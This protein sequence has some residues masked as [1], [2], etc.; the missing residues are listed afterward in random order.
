MKSHGIRLLIIFGMLTLVGIITFQVF[1]VKKTYDIRVSHFNQTIS[2]ALFDVAVK[3]ADYNK[4]LLQGKTPVHQVSTNSFIVEVN[5]MIDKDVLELFLRREFDKRN[6][7]LDFEYAIFDCHENEM[8]FGRY[9]SMSDPHDT[10]PSGH[11]FA[12]CEDC[13]YYFNIHFPSMRT[14]VISDMNVWFISSA[15]LLSAVIFFGWSL[16][17]VFRQKRLSEI[18]RDFINNMTHEFKTPIST[19]SISTEVLLK[20]GMLG[21]TGRARNYLTIIGEQNERL[22]EHVEKVLQAANIEKRRLRLELREV[23]V[24]GLLN[25]LCESYRGLAEGRGGSI[26]AETDHIPMCVMADHFHCTNILVNLIDNALKYS[27]EKPEI[28]IRAHPLKRGVR[29]TVSDNGIGIEKRYLKRVFDRFFRVPTGALHNVKGFGL[30]L[31][32]VKQVIRAHG[33]KIALE[34]TPGKGTTVLIDIPERIPGT[35]HQI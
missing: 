2:V 23:E 3:I 21:D 16:Y 11:Q 1:W 13:T 18:Q 31:H 8:V 12:R 27:E 24:A 5:D 26:Y 10:I 17:L 9:V 19:I 28:L 33:W 4:S 15:I 14:E 32:Y 22:R 29:I 35:T 30:G 20:E 6:I 7:A 34:S 25:T